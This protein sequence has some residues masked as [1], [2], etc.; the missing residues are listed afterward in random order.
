MSRKRVG[1]TLLETLLLVGLVSLVAGLSV[2]VMHLVNATYSRV[3][4]QTED[5]RQ[6]ARFANR[7]HQDA[8]RAVSAEIAA[9]LRTLTLNYADRSASRYELQ[10]DTLVAIY[11]ANESLK[12]RESFSIHVTP[13]WRWERFGNDQGIRLMAEAGETPVVVSAINLFGGRLQSSWES[14]EVSAEA[15]RS[16]ADALDDSEPT[17]PLDKEQTDA[18]S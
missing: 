4:Q 16:Q 15:R 13:E 17:D 9:D 12:K 14:S 10:T 7:F 5:V 8:H 2:S 1:T 6:H 3:D 11:L 18:T